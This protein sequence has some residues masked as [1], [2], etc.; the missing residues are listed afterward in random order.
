MLINCKK[1]NAKRI[2]VSTALMC[3]GLLLGRYDFLL[4]Q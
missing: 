1:Q 3:F 2:G 4:K